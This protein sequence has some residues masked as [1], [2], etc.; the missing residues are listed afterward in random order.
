MILFYVK[1]IALQFYST[2]LVQSYIF[3]TKKLKFL[4]EKNE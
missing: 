1:S 2:N 3:F 4:G